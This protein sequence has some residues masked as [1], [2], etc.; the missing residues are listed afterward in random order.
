MSE[1]QQSGVSQR[2]KML[3]W[4]AIGLLVALV[5]SFPK[6]MDALSADKPSYAYCGA[7]GA[8]YNYSIN[9]LKRLSNL[10]AITDTRPL[11]DA[12][13]H[14]LREMYAKVLGAV[15]E[16]AEKCDDTDWFAET[17]ADFMGAGGWGDKERIRE[18]LMDPAHHAEQLKAASAAGFQSSIELTHELERRAKSVGIEPREYLDLCIFR[19]EVAAKI[20][21]DSDQESFDRWRKVH[22]IESRSELKLADVRDGLHIAGREFQSDPKEGLHK[23]PQAVPGSGVKP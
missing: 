16:A 1:V 7:G 18:A 20:A 11:A 5:F 13:A 3:V 22:A 12:E 2:V 4:L 9:D 10:K 19:T 15:R 8:H 23:S 21:F 6:I 14:E 17:R